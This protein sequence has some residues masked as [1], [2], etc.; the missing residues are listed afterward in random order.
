MGIVIATLTGLI[1]A[2]ICAVVLVRDTRRTVRIYE[3]ERRRKERQR[4][5]V[6]IRDHAASK[7]I[8][9]EDL[10]IRCGAEGWSEPDKLKGEGVE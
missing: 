5:H 9:I 3:R 2:A 8:D 4:L 7:G 10:L 1:V 6:P